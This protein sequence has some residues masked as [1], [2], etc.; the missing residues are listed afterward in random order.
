MV[1]AAPSRAR[2]PPESQRVAFAWFTLVGVGEDAR[3]DTRRRLTIDQ[4]ADQLGITVDAVRGRVKRGTIAHERE[5]GRV[6]VFVDADQPGT[7]RDQPTDQYGESNAL[8]SQLRDEN[9]YLR[10]EN[11]RKD[12]I[13]MQQAISMRQLSAPPES[14]EAPEPR[15]DSPGPQE[16]AQEPQA[17][18][19]WQRWFGG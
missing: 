1:E 17:R 12:E 8:I 18:S 4:A 9:A 7:S 10:E 15:S 11:R 13:I 3:R 14:P 16:A 2:L 6:Y 5:G 19:W